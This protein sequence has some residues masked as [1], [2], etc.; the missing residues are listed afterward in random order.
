MESNIHT[1]E[2]SLRTDINNQTNQ[3]DYKINNMNKTL[4]TDIAANLTKL[5]QNHGNDI[6][7]NRILLTDLVNILLL[8]STDNRNLMT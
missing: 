3:I 7:C 4:N 1:L 2:L 8:L 5:I 6:F